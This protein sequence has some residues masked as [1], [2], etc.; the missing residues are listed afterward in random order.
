VIRP[1]NLHIAYLTQEFEVDPTRTVKEEFWRA[2]GEANRV[3]ESLARVHHDMESAN[4]QEL[5]KLIDKMDRLQRQFEGLDGY[6]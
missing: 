6:G 2:F 1:A 4:P 5:D 3:H